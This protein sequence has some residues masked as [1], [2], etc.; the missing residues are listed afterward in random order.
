MTV[1]FGIESLR[2]DPEPCQKTGPPFL[3]PLPFL[4]LEI[5]GTPHGPEFESPDSWEP[6]LHLGV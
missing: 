4:L 1:T 3:E 6:C 2:I 5:T